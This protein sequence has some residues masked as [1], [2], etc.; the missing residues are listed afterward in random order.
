MD[1]TNTTFQYQKTKA[2]LQHVIDVLEQPTHL[3]RT[4]RWGVRLIFSCGKLRC[5]LTGK[6]VEFADLF[7][8]WDFIVG[9]WERNSDSG[10]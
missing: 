5:L 8:C 2:I 6:M 4:H 7:A 3:L 1:S 10:L 9:N